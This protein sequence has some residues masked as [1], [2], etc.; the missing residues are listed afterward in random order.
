MVLNKQFL[1][2]KIF[3]FKI[4]MLC[5]NCN[6]ILIAPRALSCGHT[7]CLECINTIIR[8]SIEP[9]PHKLLKCP[10]CKMTI[11]DIYKHYA[12][13]DLI[14]QISKLVGLSRNIQLEKQLENEH[15]MLISEHKL[16]QHQITAFKKCKL[17]NININ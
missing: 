17:N 15:N 10:I 8:K 5:E 6:E 11:V 14:E 4:K 13:N 12:I 1:H 3:D 2:F 16:I 9:V 7:L